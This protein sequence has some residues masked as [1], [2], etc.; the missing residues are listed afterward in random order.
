[1]PIRH[2]AIVGAGLI[3]GSWALGLKRHAPGVTVTASDRPDVL[4]V[5]R[6]RGGCDH[7]EEDPAQAVAQADL[8]VLAPPLAALPHVL[9][10][11]TP[12]VRPDALVTDAGSVKTAIGELGD[13]ALPGQFVGG[14]PMAGS[15]HAGVAHASALLFEN[16]A[17]ALC[18]S[19]SSAD[20]PR[21]RALVELIERLGA[22]VLTLDAQAHDQA[23]AHVSHLPQLLAVALVNAV[24]AHAEHTPSARLLA[25]GGFRDLTRIA[26]SPYATWEGILA[27][28]A[29]ATGEALRAVRAEID[30]LDGALARDDRSL[31]RSAFDSAN[32]TRAD[33]PD[34][35]KG[36][37]RAYPE[38]LLHATDRPGFLAEV[39]AA[40][41]GAGLNVKDV[42]LLLVRE[43]TG[44]SFRLAFDSDQSVAQALGVLGQ[45]GFS[46]ERRA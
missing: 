5:L 29:G 9:R 35:R 24:G 13:A 23:V 18:P 21:M 22:R 44:G 11:I 45:A 16:A 10:T 20:H 26:S 39:F 25:A 31:L 34:R 28:N 1:L 2:V 7:A 42:E 30:R 38:V 17:Y 14:H 36:L 8:V 33:V 19:P 40:L 12:R 43:G 27:A 37:L 3:G 46:A 41:A 4:E 15:E 32:R 6:A